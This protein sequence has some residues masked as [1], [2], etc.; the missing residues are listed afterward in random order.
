MKKQGFYPF[1]EW[2]VHPYTGKMVALSTA[3]LRCIIEPL[4]SR[5]SSL[6]YPN[7]V[8]L[9]DANE[10]TLYAIIWTLAENR[11]RNSIL[12][13]ICKNV[14]R[15]IRYNKQCFKK[16]NSFLF[17]YEKIFKISIKTGKK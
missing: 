17:F 4:F 13:T 7:W 9:I 12:S 5:R 3:S 15:I 1:S 8:A 14:T 6:A 10:Q 11:T 16:I 2:R